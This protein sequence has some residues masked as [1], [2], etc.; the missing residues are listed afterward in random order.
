VYIIHGD[1]TDGLSDDPKD[2]KALTRP[3]PQY[4]E[5]YGFSLA[6]GHFS[7]KNAYNRLSG[8]KYKS[9]HADLA[10]G[11]PQHRDDNGYNSGAV[12]IHEN[13]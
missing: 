4:Q 12:H 1:K 10:I 13:R 11:A 3:S 7:K 8:E 9:S 2:Q 6:A 5:W